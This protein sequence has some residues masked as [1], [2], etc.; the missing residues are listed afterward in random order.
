MKANEFVKKYGWKK[1]VEVIKSIPP[2][3]SARY[4]S[5]DNKYS[6]ALSSGKAVCTVH[7]KRLVDS[8]ELVEF[9]GGLEIAKKLDNDL[10]GE[11]FKDVQIAIDDVESCQ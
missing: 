4:R 3:N 8:Y 6:S 2:M 11:N 9:C 7:L 5:S 1:A 10:L